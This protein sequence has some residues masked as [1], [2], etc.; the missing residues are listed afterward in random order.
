[1]NQERSNS[2]AYTPHPQQLLLWSGLL[3]LAFAWIFW[4]FFQRQVLFAIKQQADWGHTLI[5]PFIAGYFVWLCRNRLLEKPFKRAWF[6]IVLLIFGLGWYT[7]CALGPMALHHHNLMGIGVG[8]SLVGIVLFIFGWNAMKYLWFPLLYLILFGQTISDRLMEVVTFKLQDI[9]SIG[10]YYG[11]SFLGLDVTRSGNTIDIFYDGELYPL[12]IAEA[13]SG[14]RMLMAFFAL[15]V[16]MAYTGLRHFWQRTILVLLAVPTAVFVNIL[17]VMTLGIL[18]IAD[19]GFATGD[20]HTFIGTLWLIPAFLIYLGIVWLLK[21]IIIEDD[22]EVDDEV[23]ASTEIKFNQSTTVGFVILI[24]LLTTSAV[25][26][27]VGVQ[28]LNV[29]LHKEAVYPRQDLAVIPSSLGPWKSVGEDSRFDKAGV[30]ALG[31]DMYLSRNYS[32]PISAVP[33]VQ[34]HIAYYTGQIDAVPHVPDRCMVAGG[35]I[36]LTAE[37]VTV[38][39]DVGDKSWLLDAENELDG[40]QFP[41]VTK[42]NPVIGKEEIIHMPLG[43]FEIRTTEFSHPELGDD[44]VIAGY[45]FVANGKTTA[46]P[47]QIRLL[48]FNPASKYAYY[49]KVQFTIRGNQHFTIDDYS[50]IVSDLSKELMPDIMACLPDWVEVT[51]Q[52]IK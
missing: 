14:M 31:T 32:N 25:A 19:S 34:L 22:E 26:L 18:S 21:N 51:Q 2:A 39:I 47:E 36:P 35:F 6:G 7:L 28:A 1:M 48:A 8:A 41:Y 52:E 24:G 20:F 11:L 23:S 29:Y 4:D 16:A 5:I 37:P 9:A 30:E 43:E 17:R 38:S 15:G 3:M 40:T 27:Q 49:C 12:N 45:F 13:C 10:S 42:L 46:Y 33:M 50:E 44:R